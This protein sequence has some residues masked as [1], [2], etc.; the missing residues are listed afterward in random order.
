[1]DKLPDIRINFPE[2]YHEVISR[3]E[4]VD[5]SPVKGTMV[6]RPYGYAIWEKIRTILDKKIKETGTS[7]AYFPLFIPESFLKKEAKHVEGF[8]PELAVV[9]H[10]GGKKLAEPLV[11]R[12]T[13]ETIVY[14]MFARWIKS[15][16]D[17]PYKINQWA[18]VV[19][20]E[21]RTRPFLRTSEFLWQEGHTAHSTQEEAQEMALEILEIYRTLAE[22]YLAIPVVTGEKS[23]SERFAGADKTFTFEAMMQDGKALQMGTTHMLAHR[24]SQAFG[25]QF[26]DKDKTMKAPYCTSWGIS[27]RLI[28]A[29]I[30]VHGDQNGLIIPPKIAPIPVVIIPIHKNDEERSD[31]CSTAQKIQELLTQNEID[32]HI[33]DDPEKTPGAKFYD[34]ELRG[35][36]VRIEI[37]PRDVAQNQVVLVNRMETDKQ[38]RKQI[39]PIDHVQSA[40]KSL[41]SHIQ[42]AL[43]H[44]AHEFQ[45]EHWDNEDKLEIF[46]PKLEDCNGFFQTGWCGSFECEEKLKQY[47]GT[48][49]CL[50]DES[51]HDSC[52][53]CELESKRDVVIAKTY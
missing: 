51:L 5:E 19:R 41:C 2:W 6:I 1:M 20:W 30:M 35:V 31:V 49:R 45:Q 32:S 28:G 14:H 17:L 33:D 8:S 34:W 42:K 27:T 9:T 47:K 50:L 46:G 25:I 13:S 23:E 21:M 48:I 22:E 18:N 26:Q 29:L 11:I 38:K 52:F 16:R 15:W 24:F 43:F 3:A 12:P 36:P 40:T 7:N 4:L 53:A 39:V 37:G 44:R 10:A